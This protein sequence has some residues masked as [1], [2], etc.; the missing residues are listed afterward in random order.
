MQSNQHLST[1]HNNN[2]I[3]VYNI[4]ILYRRGYIHRFRHVVICTYIFRIG[5]SVG[6]SNLR[7]LDRKSIDTAIFLPVCKNPCFSLT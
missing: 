4:N 7:P 2:T 5:K 3:Y 6:G 1:Y